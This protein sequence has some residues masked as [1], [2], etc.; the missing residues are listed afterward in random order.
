MNKETTN[1]STMMSPPEK[2]IA[3]TLNPTIPQTSEVLRAQ[4]RT[5]DFR[6]IIDQAGFFELDPDTTNN[7]EK[8]GLLPSNFK[9]HHLFSAFKLYSMGARGQ[10]LEEAAERSPFLK[11][12]EKNDLL[13]ISYFIQ[14]FEASNIPEL[15]SPNDLYLAGQKPTIEIR[16]VD[17]SASPAPMQLLFEKVNGLLNPVVEPIKRKVVGF[18][19]ERVKDFAV[20]AIKAGGKRLIK[21]GAK[22]AAKAGVKLAA[23]AG[24]QATLQAIGSSAPV[25]GNIVAAVVGFLLTDVFPWIAKKF[26]GIL[27]AITGERDF[28]KQMMW[29][30]LGASVISLGL[31]AIPLAALF[32]LAALGFATAIA[33]GVAIAGGILGLLSAIWIA[34]MAIIVP[35]IAI[36]LIIAVILTPLIIVFILFIINSSALI[37]PPH[38]DFIP[39]EVKSPY[40]EVVK[41]VKSADSSKCQP[42]ST[43]PSFLDCENDELP[44]SVEYKVTI[45]AKR[46]TLT[47]ISFQNTCSVTKD[48]SVPSCNHPTPSPPSLISATQPFTYTYTQD[49]SNDFRDSLVIDNFTVTA[50]VESEQIFDT[51]SVGTASVQIGNPPTSCPSGWPVNFGRINQGAYTSESHKGQEAIDI[52][53]GIGNEVKATHT[54]IV[55]VLE[56]TCY[57]HYVEITSTCGNLQFVSQYLHLDSVLVNSGQFVSLGQTIGLSGNSGRCTSGPHLHYGYRYVPSGVPS[58]P[59]DPPYMW[60]PYIPADIPRGCIGNLCDCPDINNNSCGQGWCGQ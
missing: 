4:E 22:I 40:I 3:V 36:P 51:V 29:L 19:K 58:Y 8:E 9:S 18:V 10:D 57:G 20:K 54:G 45:T 32:G 2:L 42:N 59:N 33:G 39:G 26:A 15:P 55:T 44:I 11:E 48:G 1:N 60:C 47:N 41:T 6:E 46:G 25:I 53:I 23:K 5:K 17:R 49:Y 7:L 56:S 31:N 35:A 50:D 52:G 24:I 43:N 13:S 28:R 34:I 16:Q 27:R 21:E 38:T 12:G 14:A 37:V 30:M